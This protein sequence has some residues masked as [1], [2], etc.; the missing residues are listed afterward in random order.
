M[1]MM[2]ATVS[3]RASAALTPVTRGTQRPPASAVAT[4]LPVSWAVAANLA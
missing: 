1:M 4:V 2:H 3:L